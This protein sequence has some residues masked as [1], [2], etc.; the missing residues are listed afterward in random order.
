MYLVGKCRKRTD[1]SK[2]GST[3][4]NI[5][6]H[7]TSLRSACRHTNMHWSQF[8]SV[9]KVKDKSTAK[10]NLKYKHKLGASDIEA[11]GNFYKSDSSSFPL[12]DK[13]YS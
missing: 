11:I 3:V 6:N 9:I 2:L 10:L 13:K 5:K 7:F 12:P 4:K 8:H 1:Q